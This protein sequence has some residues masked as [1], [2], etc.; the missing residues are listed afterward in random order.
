SQALRVCETEL[1]KSRQVVL[2]DRKAIEHVLAEQ[3]FQQSGRSD[4][5]TAAE[6]GKMV[7]ARYIISGGI[8]NFGLY[9]QGQVVMGGLYSSKTTYAKC[10]VDA[11]LID[12]ER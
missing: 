4:S 1:S 6:I 11:K 3:N 12:V 9:D 5:R 10:E 2:V 8:T 7:N